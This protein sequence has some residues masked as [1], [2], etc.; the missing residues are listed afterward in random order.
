MLL[1]GATAMAGAGAAEEDGDWRA[2]E[3]A[4]KIVRPMIESNAERL[5]RAA[6]EFVRLS[7]HPADRPVFIEQRPRR[8]PDDPPPARLVADGPTTK[9]NSNST[10]GGASAVPLAGLAAAAPLLLHLTL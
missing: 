6:E 3:L 9:P 8:R 10:S 2:A 5:D 1:C 7:G 4:K